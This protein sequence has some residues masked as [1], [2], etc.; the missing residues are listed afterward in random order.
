MHRSKSPIEHRFI[1]IGGLVERFPHPSERSPSGC[2]FPHHYGIIAL[3]PRRPGGKYLFVINLLSL[4]P[5]HTLAY[6]LLVLLA[7]EALVS[8]VLIEWRH[9]R[10]PDSRR[11]LWA[12]AGLFALRT[13]LLVGELLGPPIIA[14][15]F[16]SMEVA[17][18]ALLGWAFLTP[19]IGRRAKS[20]Y[21]I[22]SL[23][24]TL[25]CVVTFLPGWYRVLTQI[26]NRLYVAF[27][28]QSFWH[29]AS[30]FLALI[31]AVILLR[32]RREGHWL[33]VYGFAIL[34]LRFAVLCAGSLRLTTGRLGAEFSTA[35]RAS[36]AASNRFCRVFPSMPDVWYNYHR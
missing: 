36:Q 33:P 25:L 17:S 34:G 22:G 12:F 4:S 27:W 24:V 31:S 10:N 26:P 20:L 8:I 18:L 35:S 1:N 30:V 23:S 13:L 28:Q 29:A 32:R 7:L 3:Y 5:Y 21:L 2:L 16:G 14:P 11:T 9:T 15:L 6:H 19:I